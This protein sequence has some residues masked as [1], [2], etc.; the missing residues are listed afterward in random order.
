MSQRDDLL[1]GARRCLVEKGYSRTTA[2]DIAT[3]AGSHLASIGYHFG[4]KDALMNLAALEA[5]NEWGDMIERAVRATAGADP[6]QRLRVAMR[7]LLAS[8]PEHRELVIATVQAYGQAE[9]DEDIRD[10]LADAGRQARVELAAMVLNRDAGEIDAATADGL[11][12]V[13]YS[14]IV[15]L[16]V[17]FVLTPTTIPDGDQVAAAITRLAGDA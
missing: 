12:A 16:A 7:E 13:V 11:G 10:A 4:S 1:A 17:Q 9:F 14:M 6:V 15:G 5:Q 3:A 8:L 2:R